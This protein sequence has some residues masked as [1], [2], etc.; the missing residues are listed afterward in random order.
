MPYSLLLTSCIRPSSENLIKYKIQRN[1]VGTR[2]KDYL[3]ALEFWIRQDFLNHLIYIDNSDFSLDAIRHF[4]ELHNHRNIRIE[5]FQIKPQPVPA[6]FHYGYEEKEMMDYAVANSIWLTPDTTIIKCT[7]RLYF[8]K[9]E[10]LIQ[11]N[12][13]YDFIGD[14]RDYQLFGKEAHYLNTTMFLFKKDF[15]MKYIYLKWDPKYSH[16]ESVLFYLTQ[17]LSLQFS[18]VKLRF[19]FNV[20][21]SGYAAHWNKQ[22]DHPKKKIIQFLRGVC[23]MLF[24]NW[25]I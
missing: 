2:L 20:D 11:W 1:D 13:N 21:P 8:P 15:Y 25:Y 4:V 7:G 10:K 9:I 24:P 12:R 19:P 18:N 14:C 16:L 3:T 6:S 23:R 17:P 5:I 22:Y